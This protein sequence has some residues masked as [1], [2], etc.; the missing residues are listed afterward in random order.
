[1]SERKLARSRDGGVVHRSD[2]RH[3][4]VPWR[5]AD[6]WPTWVVAETVRSTP[7]LSACRVC[8]PLED[9]E[10]ETADE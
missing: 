4:R 8:N 7:W 1:M 5:W 10:K 3:A 2:C 9:S 6:K